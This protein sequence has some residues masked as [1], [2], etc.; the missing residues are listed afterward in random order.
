MLFILVKCYI[1]C[2]NYYINFEAMGCD[3]VATGFRKSMFGFNCQDVMNYI[4]STHKNFVTKQNELNAKL[5]EANSALE[6]QQNE[7]ELLNNEILKLKMELK[8]Y[9]DK[10]EEIDRLS[11]N[12]GRLYLVAQTNAKNI[13]QRAQ[14]MRDESIA[15]I[16]K[17]VGTIDDAHISLNDV[18]DRIN[19]MSAEFTTQIEELVSSLSLAKEKMDSNSLADKSDEEEFEKVYNSVDV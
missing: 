14:Q 2:Y 11:R 5:K 4:E 15:E 12:I 9:E 1:V 18:R 16:E 10:R 3:N 19:E 13:M 17:N 7:N 8:E 6:D